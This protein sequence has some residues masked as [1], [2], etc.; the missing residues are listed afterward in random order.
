MSQPVLPNFF[1]LGAAKCGT[2]SLYE[3]LKKHPEIYL[4]ATKEPR[5]F[6][7][8]EV[9]EEGIEH[10]ANSHFAGSGGWLARGDASPHYLVFEKAAARIRELIPEP[11]KVFKTNKPNFFG[12]LYEYA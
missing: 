10:Y 3:A 7:N 4:S 8:D 11:S 9:F 6:C 5:F 12:F 2:T 1:I